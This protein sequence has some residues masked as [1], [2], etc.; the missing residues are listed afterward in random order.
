MNNEALLV[1]SCGGRLV[2]IM[3][4]E[5]ERNKHNIPTGRYRRACSHLTCEDCLKN[6]CVDDTFDGPWYTKMLRT[7]EN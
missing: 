2:K 7:A 4:E 1:C 6:V 3:F 5:Q